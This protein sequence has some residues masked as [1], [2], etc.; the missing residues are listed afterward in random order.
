MVGLSER[1]D[2]LSTFSPQPNEGL[3]MIVLDVKFHLKD[4]CRDEAIAAMKT[5]AAATLQENG[6]AEYRFA[7]PLN[8]NDP[9]VLFEEWE[10]QDALNAHFE[11]EH[12]ASFRAKMEQVLQQPPVIRRY[13]VTEAGSL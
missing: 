5:V 13:V 1:D 3:V 2:I 6:C 7:L 11:T 12:L 4:G 9:I 8:D 10:S